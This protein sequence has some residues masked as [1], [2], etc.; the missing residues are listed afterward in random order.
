[1]GEFRPSRPG[2]RRGGRQK[3]S[4][5]K[6]TGDV[7]AMVLSAL[8]MAGGDEYLLAQARTNPTAFMTLVG[9]VLPMQVNG[10]VGGKL[11]IEWAKE[12]LKD[13]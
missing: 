2:E 1:M 12:P 13:V 9:K 6:L 8:E 4:V 10:D 3:G 11:I 7:K 5:N